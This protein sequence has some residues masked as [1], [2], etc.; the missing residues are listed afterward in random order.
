ML[1][2]IDFAKNMIKIVI[3]DH[4]LSFVCFIKFQDDFHQQPL[5]YED[6]I[7]GFNLFTV[8]LYSHNDEI[9]PVYLV[10]LIII[11]FFKHFCIELSVLWDL[12]DD[13]KL[14]MILSEFY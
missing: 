13:F 7:V 3:R 4:L 12:I 9:K 10:A 14:E 1:K 8:L 11:S 5:E 2:K 6:A